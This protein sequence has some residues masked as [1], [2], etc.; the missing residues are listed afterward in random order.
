MKLREFPLVGDEYLFA[1]IKIMPTV[2]AKN[3]TAALPETLAEK[4]HR[5]ANA[6]TEAVAH[7]SSSTRRENHLIYQEIIALGPAVV[8]LLFFDLEKNQRHWFTA[9]SAITG[10]DPVPE[11]DAGKILKMSHAWLTWGKENG[12]RW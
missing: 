9:L 2:Q 7:L 6:W 10:A 11:E 4:F 5:L 12:Y 3:T 1:E 8:P